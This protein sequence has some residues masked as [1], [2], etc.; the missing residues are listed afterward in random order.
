M[1]QNDGDLMAVAHKHYQAG[2]LTQAEALYQQLLER[3]PHHLQVLSWL[4]LISDQS[5]KPLDSIAY[6]ERILAL[7]P[8][9]AEAHSNLGSVLGRV[10]RIGD[11]IAH[12]RRALSLLPRDADAH[13]NLAVALYQD[14]QMEEAIAHYRQ[15]TELN[16]NHA[17]AHANLGLTLYRQGN[18][19]E[20]VISYQ[21]AIALKPDHLN[22]HNG[23]AVVLYHLGRLEEA[24]AHCQQ[25]IALEPKFF[26]AYN[27]LGTIFQKQGKLEQ[28]MAQYQRAIELNPN[29][30]SAYD[31]LGTIFQKRKDLEQAIAH[32]QKA[33]ALDPHAANAYNNLGSALKDQGR[34]EEA[35]ACC[36]KAIQLQP[37]HA[38][39]HNNLGS[40]LVEQGKFQAAIAHYEQAIYYKPDHVNAHLNLGIILLMLGNFQRGFVEYHWRWRSKQCPPLRYPDAL[41]GGS[42]L[43]GK[44]ILLTAEQ[45]FGDTIQFARYAPLVAKRGGR[46]VI[47]CQR[48]LLRL[49]ETLPGIDQCVDRDR[50]NVETHFHAPL[51][52]LPLILGTTVET[53]PANVPYLSPPTSEFQLP[54]PEA[55]T[56]PEPPQAAQKD[57]PHTPVPEPIEK[58]Y[59]ELKIGFVWASNPDNA[60]SK[61]RSCPLAHFLSLTKIPGISLYSLQKDISEADQQLLEA[62]S[63]VQDLRPQLQDFA[64]TAAAI[65]RLDLVISV[66][67]A[68]A[69]LAGAMGKSVWT[70]LP[71][72]A[73]WR[74][75]LHR[76]DTPWYP[77]MQLFRQPQE[78]DWEGVFRQVEKRLQTVM[79]GAAELEAGRHSADENREPEP[80]NQSVK[81]VAQSTMR[82]DWGNL[83]PSGCP[84]RLKQC[85]HGVLLY[86]PT[87]SLPGKSLEFYGEWLEA[88]TLLFQSL[89]RLG[90]TVVEVGAQVGTHTLFLSEAVGQSGRVLATEPHRLRFQMLCANLGLNHKTNVNA[91]QVLLRDFP[92]PH[93]IGSETGLPENLNPIM[94]EPI[95]IISLDNLK[96]SQCRLLKVSLEPETLRLFQGATVTIQRCQPVLYLESIQPEI[97]VPLIDYLNALGYDLYWHRPAL[98]NP[99][100]FLRNPEN[101]FGNATAFNMLGFHRDQRIAVQG[102]ER[103]AIEDVKRLRYS[104]FQGCEVQ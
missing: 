18:L 62:T 32:Y 57:I 54:A 99:N 69:H 100:N 17:S 102:M 15:A 34:L 87:D 30:A 72:V 77:T 7:K 97:S 96:L 94:G 47:A 104:P 24:M 27:N 5:G 81:P 86:N 43:T 12:H 25:A 3:H 45:G 8:E 101:L 23:L 89:V 14:Q 93:W 56:L 98:Y 50:V 48:P 10:G 41:W 79:Q 67:T 31:N 19:E 71:F 13:Y 78:G 28:A 49:L 66:D 42:D 68:V 84:H 91:C 22:A 83:L 29:Y 52:D 74:W 53:I 6:Y 40:S 95:Q 35:I 37:S 75:L 82:S 80:I 92:R 76:E 103:V 2:R 1:E 90:D 20:S 70:L 11:A 36:Q 16:P 44:T 39:A 33:I 58:P 9:A 38:D 60:T 88:E 61:K 63:A 46:V 4:A 55:S 59:R 21:R 64:D 85:R 73:D 51:L 65:A 26:S